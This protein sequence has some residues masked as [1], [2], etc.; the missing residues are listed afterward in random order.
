MAASSS[1]APSI[2]EGL[3]AANRSDIFLSLVDEHK[4]I[5]FKVAGTYSRDP[6]DREDLIQEIVAQLWRSFRSYDDRYRFSTW[7][8]RVALNVAISLYRNEAMRQ[9]SVIPADES[10][11]EIAQPE[12]E[13]NELGDDI[14]LWRHFI[15]RLDE[16]DRAVI[17]LYLDGNP[18]ANIAEVLG[19]SVSNVGTKIGRIKQKLKRDFA[20]AT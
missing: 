15:A 1:R 8:Y 18:H 12:P 7:M 4:R 2:E 20:Q 3:K 13:S 11:F 16:L 17:V 10:L 6:A 9:R 5:L 19:I 14:R